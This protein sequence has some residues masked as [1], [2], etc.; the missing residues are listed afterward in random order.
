M[1]LSLLL[2]LFLFWELSFANPL[3][4]DDLSTDKLWESNGEGTFFQSG[5]LGEPD[6]FRSDVVSTDCATQQSPMDEL[7][8]LPR[9]DDSCDLPLP[10]SSDTLQ[11]FQ[12]PLNSLEQSGVAQEKDG[13]PCEAL[14]LSGHKYHTCCWYVLG[15]YPDWKMAWQCAAGFGTF[16]AQKQREAIFF[17]S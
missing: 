9:G 16:L 15:E 3:S 5:F 4:N 7:S 17:R 13:N 1:H 10:L 8:L 6:L 14:T 12:D 11:L 2:L